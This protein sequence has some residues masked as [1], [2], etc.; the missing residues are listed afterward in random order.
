MLV[1]GYRTSS[2]REWISSGDLMYSIAAIVNITALLANNTIIQYSIIYSN[3]LIES[4]S[5]V[6]TTHAHKMVTVW[7]DWYVN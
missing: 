1:T 7:G 4:K 6:L 5:C 3:L 2:Y